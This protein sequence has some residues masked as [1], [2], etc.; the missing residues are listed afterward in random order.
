MRPF[1]LFVV[2][3]LPAGSVTVAD[4]AYVRSSRSP[5]VTGVN[6]VPVSGVAAS[7]SSDHVVFP[8]PN[9]KP[10]AATTV[11]SYRAP[12]TETLKELPPRAGAG[13]PVPKSP[14]RMGIGVARL[15]NIELTRGAVGAVVS[16]V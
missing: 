7:R 3:S 4:T 15:P 8:A 5:S 2:D 9:V 12:A 10:P 6:A 14:V 1:G 11:P 16:S 13:V